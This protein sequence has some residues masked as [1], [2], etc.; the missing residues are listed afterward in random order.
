MQWRY[1]DRW[2]FKAFVIGTHSDGISRRISRYSF[3][4]SANISSVLIPWIGFCGFAWYGCRRGLCTPG[5]HVAGARSS[6][7]S[8]RLLHGTP[9][10]RICREIS[11]DIGRCRRD[12]VRDAVEMQSRYGRYLGR[13]RRDAPAGARTRC[14]PD[15]Q[16]VPIP[17]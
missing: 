9:A 2:P 4:I 7:G 15:G 6:G 1:V 12:D 14:D 8:T 10:R 17:A 11:G 5:T 16:E 3:H 13:S